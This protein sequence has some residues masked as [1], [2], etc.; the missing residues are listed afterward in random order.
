MGQKKSRSRI[1]PSPQFQLTRTAVFLIV[2]AGLAA[3]FSLPARSFWDFL[4]PSL[5]KGLVAG[6]IFAP[7]VLIARVVMLL[8][9]AGIAGVPR[10]PIHKPIA[11]AL[12]PLIV[13][14]GTFGLGQAQPVSDDKTN[15][16]VTPLEA[17]YIL[18]LR[19]LLSN[20][21][22]EALTRAQAAERIP[23]LLEKAMSLGEELQRESF[24]PQAVVDAV[25][26]DPAALYGWVRDQTF[27]VP[28]RGALRGPVG[29]LMDRLGNSLDRSLLLAELLTLSGYEVRFAHA[30][31]DQQKVDGLLAKI[32]PIAVP[33]RRQSRS[34]AS[35]ELP[36]VKLI[37]EYAANF[38]ISSAP[39]T[40]AMLELRKESEK[41]A[42]DASRQAGERLREL[43]TII[44]ER[45]ADK[46]D[47]R[48]SKTIADHWWIQMEQDGKWIDLDPT[49]SDG[50]MG[51]SV[52][53]PQD[54]FEVGAIPEEAYCRVEVSVI[55]ERWAGDGLSE[56]EVL[57]HSLRPAEL[58]EQ[59]VVLSHAPLDWPADLSLKPEDGIA[60]L[61]K[62]VL[63]VHEWL[64]VIQVGADQ[65]YHASFNE[66]GEIDEQ[67]AITGEAGAPSA[68]D[69]GGLLG[70]T[71]EKASKEAK[72]RKTPS[73][74]NGVLTAEWID[75]EIAVPGSPPRRIR[76]ESFDLIGPAARAARKAAA[77]PT[78]EADRLARG[79]LLL[80]QTAVL[81]QKCQPTPEFLAH[82]SLQPL[83]TAGDE[84]L[85]ALEG[86]TPPEHEEG[87]R[88][89][90]SMLPAS[91]T[92]WKYALSRFTTSPVGQDVY[93]DTPNVVTFRTAPAMDPEGRLVYQELVDIV[94]NDVAVR[95]GVKLGPLAVRLG[96]GVADTNAERLVLAGSP[97]VTNTLDFFSAAA[98]QGLKPIL[99]SGVD[100]SWSQ[101]GW[102]ADAVARVRNDIADHFAVIVP[103]QPVVVGGLKRTGWWRVDLRTGT[104]V[105]VMD[106]GFHQT[107]YIKLVK[108]LMGQLLTKPG[109]AV[110]AH[111]VTNAPGLG[112]GDLVL[113]GALCALIGGLAGY[114]LGLF[115]RPA[116]PPARPTRG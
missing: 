47:Q 10:W 86:G 30:T 97:A 11:L 59:E 7:I 6:L 39:L 115:N 91:D 106:T 63:G 43:R 61:K 90:A 25:G 112:I 110:L 53:A 33:D 37:E 64:P 103:P 58:N 48:L 41:F 67:P 84:V 1:A 3:L 72:G 105:G 62:A 116:P 113:F 28:Y 42:A 2:L 40:K 54:T 14:A 68:T 94:A 26:D 21:S 34:A 36:E 100:N 111:V 49:P 76:R 5:L 107:E 66:N 35:S 96:Q 13:L 12:I 114:A 88:L 29:V 22:G 75:Y 77:A 51:Q 101:T 31:L 8:P 104:C 93:I 65:I 24:D 23:Y 38:Q 98:A 74:E 70:G 18:F 60:P 95:A 20:P 46:D 78:S 50:R 19:A 52:K 15:A 32:R 4:P 83:Q 92:L 82:L 56:R 81:V 89:F 57:K 17:S 73:R 27:F 108:Y 71:D 109:G 9:Q 80:G 16:P 99:A 85:S 55:V 44:G 79:L 69:V 102:T 45:A 87:N